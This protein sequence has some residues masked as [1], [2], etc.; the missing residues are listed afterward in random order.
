MKILWKFRNYKRKIKY[1]N[2]QRRMMKSLHYPPRL[3]LHN[4][5]K[6][7]QIF[8]FICFQ[9]IPN[10]FELMYSDFYSNQSIAEGL[11]KQKHF[12]L[13]LKNNTKKFLLDF[14][15]FSS[16]FL[17]FSRHKKITKIKSKFHYPPQISFLII[18]HLNFPSLLSC[19]QLTVN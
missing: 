18:P 17:I 19:Q 7:T 15:Q 4:N 12:N 3:F 10:K 6:F 16:H 5:S 11:R 13:F 8:C 2:L 1:W 9:L 14:S